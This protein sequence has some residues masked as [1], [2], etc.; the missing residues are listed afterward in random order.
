MVEEVATGDNVW[1][2]LMN[3]W[4]VKTYNDHETGIYTN[5]MDEI[6]NPYWLDYIQRFV[7]LPEYQFVP[8]LKFEYYSLR[9]FF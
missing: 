9:L 4:T 5:L 8:G 6:A 1:S 7:G 2:N 3:G